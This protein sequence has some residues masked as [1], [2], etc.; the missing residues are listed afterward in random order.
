MTCRPGRELSWKRQAA[1]SKLDE[2]KAAFERKNTIEKGVRDAEGAVVEAEDNLSQWQATRTQ[3]KLQTASAIKDREAAQAKVNVVQERMWAEKAEIRVLGRK[4]KALDEQ[5]AAQEQAIQALEKETESLKAG[6]LDESERLT[7]YKEEL[8]WRERLQGDEQ[9]TD[10][11]RG[12]IV[13]SQ[14]AMEMSRRRRTTLFDKR[15]EI[16]R[17]RTKIERQR[18][19]LLQIRTP[20]Q[21]EASKLEHQLKDLQQLEA[22]LGLQY[23]TSRARGLEA[24]EKLKEVGSFLWPRIG[25]TLSLSAE[26]LRCVSLMQT[27]ATGRGALD[28]M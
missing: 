15:K 9:M 23:E 12:Q 17:A 3:A 16:N 18:M 24:D 28:G 2:V 22:K 10:K 8:A 20:H 14:E 21:L 6:E 19:E 27:T 4:N 1:R 5:V 7:Q 25:H 13:Q 11:V 26:L